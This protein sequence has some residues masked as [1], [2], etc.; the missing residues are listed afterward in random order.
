MAVKHRKMGRKRGDEALAA[1]NEDLRETLAVIKKEE[2][3]DADT[4]TS[5]RS[6]EQMAADFPALRAAR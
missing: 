5:A 2:E 6:V 4:A 3:F 1:L